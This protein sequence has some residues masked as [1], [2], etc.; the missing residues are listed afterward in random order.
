MSED[1]GPDMEPGPPESSGMAKASLVLG[2]LGLL[3]CGITARLVLGLLGLLAY[4]IT[5]IVGLILGIVS[6]NRIK[7][8]NG[9]WG[10]KGMATGGIGVSSITIV[11]AA[12][13]NLLPVSM[14]AS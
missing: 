1:A 5:A 6:L 9:R 14:D 7:T 11:I 3:T 4:G 8:S 12:I 10:G 2:L 13:V